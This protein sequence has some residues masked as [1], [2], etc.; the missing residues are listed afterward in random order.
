MTTLSDL[1]KKLQYHDWYYS[2]SDDYSVVRRG[3]RAWDELKAMINLFP[4]DD[5]RP[6]WDK[7]APR[8]YEG[9]FDIYFPAK[10]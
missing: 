4:R 9:K 8:D 5:V 10:E 2:Y 1:E 6:L 7:H 3:E